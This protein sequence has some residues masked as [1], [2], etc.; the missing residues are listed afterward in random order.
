MPLPQQ[1]ATTRANE[2]IAAHAGSS[3][4]ISFLFVMKTGNPLTS[5]AK[6]S[7]VSGN[8]RKVYGTMR[9]HV[10]VCVVP[11]LRLV[12]LVNLVITSI[13]HN[14]TQVQT[15]HVPP[16]HKPAAVRAKGLNASLK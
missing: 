7:T 6:H 12:E 2:E 16:Q 1:I 8:A 5:V 10:H 14:Q 15:R 4:L 3:G 13:R 11:E 9:V